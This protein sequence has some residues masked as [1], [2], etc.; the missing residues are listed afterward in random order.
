MGGLV[1]LQ[2][3]ER[4]ED[5]RIAELR[6]QLASMR[7][8]VMALRMANRELE[9]IVD[10]DTLT[11]LYNRR[12]FINALND[13]INRF[14]RY[15]TRAVVVFV[16]VDGLKQ[17]NDLH[18]HNGGDFALVHMARLLAV[19]VRTTDV[20]ARI[21][22]DEFALILDE[23]GEE[24]ARIK[25]TALATAIRESQCDY[26]GTTL[27]VRASFGMAL[28]QP[29]DRDEDVMGRADADMYAAK[30]TSRKTD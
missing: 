14:T 10:R 8:E 7:A 27:P 2:G 28:I 16:D 13:R 24:E 22:G 15:G 20:A 9:R 11:P 3:P 6:V 25:I 1:A 23:L 29:G 18:G 4:D 19:N 30:R 5:P 21:G 12:Y 26:A 17:V